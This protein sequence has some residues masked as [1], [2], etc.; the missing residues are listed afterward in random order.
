MFI[1]SDPF[2]LLAMGLVAFVALI[3]GVSALLEG[4]SR[5]ED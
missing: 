1:D 5:N 4:C 2:F 3:W